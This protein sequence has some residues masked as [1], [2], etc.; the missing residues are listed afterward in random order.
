[1][2]NI[3]VIEESKETSKMVKEILQESVPESRVLVAKDSDQAMETLKT[4]D[5]DIITLSLTMPQ[6]GGHELLQELLSSEFS[7]IPIIVNSAAKD[8]DGIDRALKAG[9]VNYFIK[10][11][12]RDY[13]QMIM[14]MVVRN[15][16]EH[17]EEKRELN[18]IKRLLDNEFKVAGLLQKS[19]LSIY[20]NRQTDDVEIR[21]FFKPSQNISSALFDFKKVDRKNW[22]FMVDSKGNNM[23]QLMVSMLLKAV[24]NEGI[25]RSD[26]PG[27]IMTAMNRKLHELYPDMEVPFSS[28]IIGKIENRILTYSNAGFPNPEFMA[29]SSE[30]K[31]KFN[32]NWHMLGFDEDT[33]YMDY[34]HVLNPDDCLL[35]YTDG[36][37]KNREE[38]E[39]FKPE[40][41]MES[42]LDSYKKESNIGDILQTILEEFI[43][44]NS[45]RRED[46]ALALIRVK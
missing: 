16:L 33:Y 42:I 23:I 36:L 4:Y 15:A 34:I 8:M 26:S 20:N 21:A 25:N 22:F 7:D 18:Y 27:E 40:E 5:I 19:M 2:Y 6:E 14:S 46:V 43:D 37:Y 10:S 32:V 3:L 28:C 31:K 29:E 11:V 17:Y 41:A 44:E 35:L 13:I 24:F 38:S 39:E 9:A 1:M 12:K 45:S 30:D